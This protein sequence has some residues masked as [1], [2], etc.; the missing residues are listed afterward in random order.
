M[1]LFRCHGLVFVVLL[2]G[3]CVFEI[4]V[5]LSMCFVYIWGY[6]LLF[7][8]V[9][10][11]LSSI[12]LGSLGLLFGV[13]SCYLVWIHYLSLAYYLVWF[14]VGFV[15]CLLCLGCL[16]C[17]VCFACL[18][19]CFGLIVSTFGFYLGFGWYFGYFWGFLLSRGLRGPWKG[20]GEGLGRVVRGF[21]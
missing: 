4:C 2:L 13:A 18:G 21:V 5:L 12:L 20:F 11:Y 3:I 8:F 17:W 6:K 1:L 19:I 7:G 14:I 16:F 15:C 10:C 9:G